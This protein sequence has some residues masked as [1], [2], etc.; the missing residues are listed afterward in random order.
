[1]N[2]YYF[3]YQQ[4]HK[5]TQQC[6][7][8]ITAS[9]FMPDMILAIGAGGFIPARI[10][11]TYISKPIFTVAISYYDAQDKPTEMPKKH[12]WLDDIEIAGKKILLVDEV[13]D[14]RSTLEYCLTEL[15]QHNP[16]EVAVFVLHNKN[17]PKRGKYPAAIKHIFIGEELEDKWIRYPWDAKNIDEHEQHTT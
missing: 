10:L 1:M 5:T 15:L 8:K 7:E 16:A 4:I 13:D 14:S 11:R 3:S 17:K 12:Q 2:E 9:G 6:A